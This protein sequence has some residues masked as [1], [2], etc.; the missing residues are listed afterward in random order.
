MTLD[1]DRVVSLFQRTFATRPTVVASAP[2]RVNLLGEHLDYN[3]GPVLPFAIE[4]RTWVAA[5]PGTGYSLWSTALGGAPVR[6]EPGPRRGDWTD[7]IL[8]VDR[9]LRAGDRAPEGGRLA[10]VSDLPAGAGLS[11]SAALAVAGAA[12][13][14]AL[15]GRRLDPDAAADTAYRAEHD[16]VGVRCGRMDQTV[17]AHATPGQAILLETG[18]GTRREVPL[19]FRTWVLPTGVD[20]SLADGGYN[21][22]RAEC[23]RALEVCRRR[24][25]ALPAL[26][27]LEPEELPDVMAELP[28]P[29]DRRVRH[30]VTETARTR[31]A[32][33]ALDRGDLAEV[34]R[35]MVEGHE[36]LRDDYQCSVAQADALVEAALQDGAL[37]ARLTG[38]GWGGSVIM[39]APEAV[40]E[41][42]AAAA[43]EH[44]ARHFGP[45]PQ[46]WS[47][48][49]AAGMRLDLMP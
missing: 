13:L 37:G 33:A 38:A 46:P 11:S 43:C 14:V 45:V 40:G 47:T 30:V 16:Y 17:V 36:S 2:G 5:G 10:V 26:A 18:T 44:L 21:A 23:E 6:R 19:G 27:G 25:P 34:G 1:L 49:A 31:R 39:L 8:G 12:A 9:E 42:A 7:Y 48:G 22:R 15:T 29:L 24:V 32:A 4:R 35:L 20:H 41:R 28:P 3:A